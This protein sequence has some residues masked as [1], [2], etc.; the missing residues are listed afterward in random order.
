MLASSPLRFPILRNVA[1][2]YLDHGSADD[3]VPAWNAEE[4]AAAIRAQAVN[5]EYH[6][7]AGFGHDL[8]DSTEFRDVQYQIYEQ[9]LLDP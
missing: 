4:M 7:Y 9:F 2:V 6:L 5:L 1:K 3:V 8:G